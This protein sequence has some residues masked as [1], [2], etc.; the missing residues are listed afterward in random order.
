MSI[1]GLDRGLNPPE[2][3]THGECAHCFAVC[4]YDDME[5]IGFDYYCKE[6]TELMGKEE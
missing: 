4:D 6:C 1:I 3:P 5:L 2:P